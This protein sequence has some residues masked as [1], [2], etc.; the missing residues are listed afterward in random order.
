MIAKSHAF[1]TS[2]ERS[3]QYDESGRSRPLAQHTDCALCRHICFDHLLSAHP[4][5]Y[6]ARTIDA[7]AV[8]LPRIPRQLHALVQPPLEPE[9]STRGKTENSAP[10]SFCKQHTLVL[11]RT[12]YS[13]S[14][15]AA[16]AAVAAAAVVALPLPSTT[17]VHP[18]FRRPTFIYFVL[19]YHHHH[20]H[21]FIPARRLAE[22][23]PCK[24]R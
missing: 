21:H 24:L 12:K 8:S 4:I 23:P 17:A 22:P 15:T 14:R 1:S 10:L 20:H 9:R 18:H 3:Q 19:L 6:T 2:I 13:C 5:R 11:Q 7:D 16:A